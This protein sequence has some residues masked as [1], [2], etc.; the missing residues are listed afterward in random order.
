MKTPKKKNLSLRLS[1]EQTAQLESLAQTFHASQTLVIEWALRALSDYAKLHRGRAMLPI[2]FSE[3]W[4]LAQQS[5][6]QRKDVQF[7]KSP[8]PEKKIPNA[9]ATAARTVYYV[10]QRP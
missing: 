6:T 10:A 8:R 2:N 3:F 4:Q 7:P 1:D 5:A 9:A